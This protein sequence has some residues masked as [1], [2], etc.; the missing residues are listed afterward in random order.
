MAALAGAM[1]LSGIANACRAHFVDERGRL[2]DDDGRLLTVDGRPIYM[3]DL[4]RG[5]EF[6]S[7]QAWDGERT[8]PR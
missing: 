2:V 5:G 6:G 4:E 3:S 7:A 8:C 1:A